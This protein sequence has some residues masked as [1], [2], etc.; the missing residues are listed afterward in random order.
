MADLNLQEIHDLLVSV[1]HEAG[2]MQLSAT[3]SYLSSGTKKNSADL[4]TET[5]QAVEKMVNT[6]LLKS[7]P[8]F[9]FIGEETYFPGQTLTAEPTFICDP[10]DGT[11][12]FVHAFPAFC[13]SL[14]LAVNK[15]PVIGVIYNPYLDELYTAIKGQGAYLTRGKFGTK[16][17]LPLKQEP[18]PL[19]DLSTC[20]IGAEW[21]S[22][23]TGNNF[24]LRAKVFTKLAASKE[25]GG[26]M[27]H[28]IRSMGSAALNIAAVAA[29]QLDAYWEGGCWAWDVCA[30]WCILV[31]A[32]GIMVSANPGDWEPTIEGRKYLAIRGAPSG[33]KEIVEEFW[34]VIGEGR[35]DYSS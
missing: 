1:A 12:N 11:T 34:G 6:R 33:Q 21:G 4:V 18:E 7:Y 17:K 30:G 26:A 16:E 25:D 14:G 32:G 13:I 22:D 9:Q 23:R 35:L 31:E 3:P 15:T 8:T 10:I 28:S 27:V 24:D 2:Q 20:L 29:G 5:D 19:K